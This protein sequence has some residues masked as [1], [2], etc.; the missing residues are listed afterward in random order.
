MI[1]SLGK[2]I[3]SH[4]DDFKTRNTKAKIISTANAAVIS[5]LEVRDKVTG[6]FKKTE[7]TFKFFLELNNSRLPS[8]IP[9]HTFVMTEGQQRTFNANKSN[10]FASSSKGSYHAPSRKQKDTEDDDIEFRTPAQ[11]RFSKSR[12]ESSS[13]RSSRRESPSR[14]PEVRTPD[15]RTPDAGT[16]D[17]S[18]LDTEQ[19]RRMLNKIQ[20]KINEK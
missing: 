10:K 7:L 13:G 8:Y 2:K 9:R 6:E 18:N 12:R 4:F 1:D 19:L 5:P 3:L 20:D 16:P 14:T 17:I 15:I 11:D